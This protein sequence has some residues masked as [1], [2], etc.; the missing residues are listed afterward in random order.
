[1]TWNPPS[2]P[3]GPGNTGLVPD[4][5]LALGEMIGG[6]WRIYKSRFGLFLTL[7]L[8]PFLLFFGVTLLAIF[9]F[10]ATMMA[11]PGS[12]TRLEQ[13]LPTVA[14]LALVLYAALIVVALMQYVYQGRSMIAGIDLATGR[15]DPTRANLAERTRGLLGRVFVLMLLAFAAG[16]VIGLVIALVTIPTTLASAEGTGSAAASALLTMVI[17]MAAYVGLIWFGVKCTYLLLVMAEEG[18]TVVAAIK[19]SFELTR[20]AFWK[21]LGYQVVLVLMAFGLMLIPYMVLLVG[22]F[23]VASSTELAPRGVGAGTVILLLLGI[24]ALYAVLFLFIPYQ[25]IYVALMYLSRTR[26]LR[27]GQP[28]GYGPGQPWQSGPQE[29]GPWREPGQQ[30]PGLWQQSGPQDG[31]QDGPRPWERPD[32]QDPRPWQRPGPDSP[33]G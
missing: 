4:R 11:N 10:G 15:Q 32:P 3:T 8:I 1:M 27:G 26:E 19:R 30:D 23:S 20:G 22:V 31:P 5:P 33:Q 7:L 25:Y 29:P 2:F 13:W 28:A 12:S 16:L 17:T 6:A 14:G 24:V 18:L 21:T 9:V